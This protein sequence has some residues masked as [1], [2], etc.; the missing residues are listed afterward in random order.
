MGE[1]A[2][3]TGLTSGAHILRDL[4][5]DQFTLGL[6]VV[7]LHALHLRL[8]HQPVVQHQGLEEPR[9]L[10]QLLDSREHRVSFT[11]RTFQRRSEQ[12]ATLTDR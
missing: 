4:L 7:Q 3:L 11:E 6:V 1:C 8:S 2:S 5:Q 12:Q 10:H 9:A